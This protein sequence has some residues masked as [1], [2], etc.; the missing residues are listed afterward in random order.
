MSCA[1]IQ[2]GEYDTA[3]T[4]LMEAMSKNS[5]DSDAMVN[6]IVCSQLMGKPA[7]V[8]SRYMTQLRSTA[9]HCKWLA[10]SAAMEASFDRFAV[11]YSV[12]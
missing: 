6:L 11:Q 2:Q 5:Q 12:A 3:E 7:D 8:I 9:P 4:L 1:H 10:T